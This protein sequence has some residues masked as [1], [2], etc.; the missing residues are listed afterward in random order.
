M[1]LMMNATPSTSVRRW[2]RPIPTMTATKR[3]APD[4]ERRAS[5]RWVKPDSLPN[6]NSSILLIQNKS[7]VPTFVFPVKRRG[8]EEAFVQSFLMLERLSIPDQETVVGLF[9]VNLTKIQGKYRL[10]LSNDIG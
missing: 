1:T 7:L 2:R 3:N 8:F 4:T 10:S 5:Q 6:R 9:R